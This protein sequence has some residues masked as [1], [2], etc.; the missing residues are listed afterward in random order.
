MGE[1]LRG[2][3]KIVLWLLSL[4]VE[5]KFEIVFCVEKFM[6]NLKL[7]GVTFKQLVNVHFSVLTSRGM[8]KKLLSPDVSK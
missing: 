4:K 6:S 2:E 5:Q 8:G 1:F 7:M 3:K